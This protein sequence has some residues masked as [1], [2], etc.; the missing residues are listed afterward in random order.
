[1]GEWTADETATV[2]GG[3]TSWC[4]AY[5]W[6]VPAKVEGT[7]KLPQGELALKQEF[8]MVSG[9]LQAEGRTVPLQNGK[10]RGDEIT[11]TAGGVQY[12]GKVNGK[13][14]DGSTRDGTSWSATR[15]G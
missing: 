7:W 5:L 4:T 11:F 9:T 6:I 12:T 13:R 3:C 14:I 2:G 15:A 1:M 10:V 8:Q